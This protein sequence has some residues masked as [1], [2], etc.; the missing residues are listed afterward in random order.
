MFNTEEFFLPESIL[1]FIRKRAD[2]MPWRWMHSIESLKQLN[3][4]L[5]K[6]LQIYKNST[7]MKSEKAM[8]NSWMWMFFQQ[9]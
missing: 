1:D 8:W 7:E 2:K 5:W 9:L 6:C 3:D 4:M